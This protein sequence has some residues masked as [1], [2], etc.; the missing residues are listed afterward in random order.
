MR[1]VWHCAALV[2]TAPSV[3]IASALCHMH[4]L[5]I[6]HM[7]VKPDNIYK[8]GDKSFKLG[9]FGLATRKSGKAKWEEG[10]SR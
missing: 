2:T 6:V 5:G 10:D 7:D 3:Q 8:C 4:Q 1:S 9:D